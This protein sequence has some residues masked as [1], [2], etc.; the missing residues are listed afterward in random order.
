VAPL[1][2][3][4]PGR[5]VQLMAVMP[6]IPRKRAS[7]LLARVVP[8]APAAALGHLVPARGA[9]RAVGGLR[10]GDEMR[11]WRHLRPLCRWGHQRA[12]R[13]ELQQA[14]QK[15]HAAARVG[16]GLGACWLDRERS[17]GRGRAEEPA[18]GH[19]RGTP[20]ARILR[21]RDG[22]LFGTLAGYAQHRARTHRGQAPSQPVTIRSGRHPHVYKQDLV[23]PVLQSSLTV[24]LLLLPLCALLV[25]GGCFA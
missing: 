6:A 11:G 15:A 25:P 1:M 23:A 13:V 17:D 7:L 18:A 3:L 14:V 9:G 12:V 5:P 20:Y 8:L 22:L 24:P 4:V 2:P 21:L 16:Q 10:Q 19:T